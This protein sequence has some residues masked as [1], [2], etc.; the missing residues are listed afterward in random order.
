[1]S[2]EAARSRALD[3]TSPRTYDGPPVVQVDELQGGV[4]VY[5][6]YAVEVSG[7]VAALSRGGSAAAFVT[8]VELD[9]S[10]RVARDGKVVREFDPLFHRARSARALPEERGLRWR[11]RWFLASSWQVLERVTDIE[12]GRS[13]LLD[14]RHPTYVLDG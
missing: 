6:P 11:G 10:V 9:T 4:V 3:L 12:V 14:R 2:I 7:R 8:T 13:W 1:M 5:A